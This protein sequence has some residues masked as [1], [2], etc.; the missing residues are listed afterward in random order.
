MHL[1]SDVDFPLPLA[2]VVHVAN[3]IEVLRPIDAGERLD[4]TV[5]AADLRAHERGRQVDIVATALVDGAQVWRGVSTYLHRENPSGP[6]TSPDE[7]IRAHRPA[8]SAVWRVGREVGPRYAAVS[9]DRNP[10]HTSRIAARVFGFPRTIAHGMWS[11]ARCLAALEGRL[12][13]RYT[14][15]VAFKL[16]VLLPSTVDF[17]AVRDGDGWR[18]SLHGHGSDRPHLTGA[19][20][21]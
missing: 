12:P 3:R 18:M 5:R 19:V 8:P 6:R 17:A 15:D 13:D 2:G 16:P 11:K 20:N 21:P 9:G 10:I 1:M 14:V 4:L 7:R